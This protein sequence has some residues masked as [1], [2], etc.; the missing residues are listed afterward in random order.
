M[1]SLF[2]MKQEHYRHSRSAAEFRSARTDPRQ[3]R[4]AILDLCLLGSSKHSRIDDFAVS[5]S[6]THSGP[7]L[8]AMPGCAAGLTSFVT[9]TCS[10]SSSQ[11]KIR[12]PPA[13]HHRTGRPDHRAATGQ[14]Q[15]PFLGRWLLLTATMFAVSAAVYA[16]RLMLA[17]RRPPFAPVGKSKNPAVHDESSG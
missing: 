6:H 5:G 8:S 1:S 7:G 13:R 3:G 12:L 17:R 16:V 10:G 14:T 9:S 2:H 11:R 15:Q 4:D